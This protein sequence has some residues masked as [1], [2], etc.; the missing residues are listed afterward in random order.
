MCVFLAQSPAQARIIVLLLFCR[1]LL[2]TRFGYAESSIVML[3]DSECLVD[4]EMVQSTL[5]PA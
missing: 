5:I 4:D 1:H 2:L 3:E